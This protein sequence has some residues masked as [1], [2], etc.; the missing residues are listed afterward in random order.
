[1]CNEKPEVYALRQSGGNW[2]ISRR[3]FLKTAG[4]GAAVM[5]A[6]LNSRFVRP[7]SAD[8]SIADFCKKAQAHEKKISALFLSADGKYLLSRSEG[9]AYD[10]VIIKCWSM[11]TGELVNSETFKNMR[12]IRT[13]MI[14]G[15]SCLLF[16]YYKRIRIISIPE[17]DV[18]DGITVDVDPGF[19]GNMINDFIV[20]PDENLYV[21]LI[22]QPEIICIKRTDDEKKYGDQSIVYT[23]RNDAPNFG[24]FLDE[25]RLLLSTLISVFVLDIGT[26]VI[27][28]LDIPTKNIYFNSFLSDKNRILVQDKVGDGADASYSLFSIRENAPIWQRY[29]PGRSGEKVD[30]RGIVL[31]PDNSMA[32]LSTVDMDIILRLISVED[33]TIIKEVNT[34]PEEI[35]GASLAAA[36]DGS[37]I[38]VALGNSIVFYSL[39]DLEVAGCPVDLS[40]NTDDTEAVE[41]SE[42][43]PVSGR[44]VTYTLPCGAAIPAGTV[45]TCNC[46]AGGVP[47]AKPTAVPTKAPCSCVGNTCGCVGYSCGCDGNVGHYW[48]PN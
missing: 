14:D 19:E 7:V 40:V 47:T 37:K 44:I 39:P 27:E 12:R 33:G 10:E 31:T 41:V 4:A 28:P 2:Q 16:S 3:D 32:V 25:N 22:S 11:E 18:S 35:N 24:G 34:G 1:M 38:A 17:M 5:G 46:V 42:T 23:C 9:S 30:I 8:E 48:H 6:A 21:S 36:P 15:K 43:D 26:Q 45:C 20:G 29:L 13:A